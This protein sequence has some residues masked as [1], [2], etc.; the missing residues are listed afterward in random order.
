MAGRL[1]QSQDAGRN[2]CRSHALSENNTPFSPRGFFLIS[3]AITMKTLYS[4]KAWA[5]SHEIQ[6]RV[7][8]L[9]LTL[10]C[11]CASS[12]YKKSDAAAYG[13]QKAAI[14]VNAESQAIDVTLAALDNLVNQPAG[15]LRPRFE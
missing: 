5:L 8:A 13:L 14:A 3:E 6:F 9:A 11:G 2:A 7:I 4:N 12:S 15:D 10:F 1:C